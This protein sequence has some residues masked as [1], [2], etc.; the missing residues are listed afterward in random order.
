MKICIVGPG[1]VG[2]ATG[3]AFIKQGFEVAFLGGGKETTGKLRKQGFTA[4]ERNTY[5]NGNYDFDI[6]ML[7]V[8]TPSVEGR[9][10]LIAVRSAAHDL[11]VRLKYSKKYHLIVVKSTV[12]PGTT[13]NI[14]IKTVE[15][16]SGKKIGQDF[17]VCMNP[18]YLREKTADEDA[19]K[20]WVILIGEYDKKSG[21]VLTLAYKDFKC[22]TYRVP[23]REAE[24]QKYV[25]NLYNAAKIAFFN[26]MREIAQAVDIDA[27]RVF[28]ISA[29][30]TEGLWNPHYGLKD[31]GPFLG[32]CLPKDTSA[33]YEWTQTQGLRADLLKSVI[34]VNDMLK[35]KL[36]IE[37]YS[38][39]PYVL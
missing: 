26:E 27:D 10:N 9:I 2:R 18:E 14:V 22:P 23:L 19:L 7:T 11:A 20:P 8:P 29:L 35:E 36:G 3:K 34:E 30:S 31:R 17:G 16:Y 4:Y 13:E 39:K 21:D 1:V 15:K 12:P 6:T 28:K 25:H 33:F 37:K 5:F 38:T 32:S 24:M